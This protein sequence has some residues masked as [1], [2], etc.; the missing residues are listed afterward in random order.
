MNPFDTGT[1]VDVAVMPLVEEFLTR[2]E[3]DGWLDDAIARFEHGDIEG[4]WRAL[5]AASRAAQAALADL[6]NS[7]EG[8]R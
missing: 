3:R 2:L 5:E 1:G 4:G 8:G 6:V 7:Y